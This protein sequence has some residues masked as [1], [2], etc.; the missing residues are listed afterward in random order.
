MDGTLRAALDDL[1]LRVIDGAR[2]EGEGFS[3]DE[4]FVARLEVILH[5][6]QVPP[7]AVQAGRAIVRDKL[8]DRFS[9]LGK[10]F[11][12]QGYDRATNRRGLV[13]F[14]IRDLQDVAPV[15]CRRGRSHN[16]SRMV[17]TP[18]RANCAA[19]SGPTPR[20]SVTGRARGSEAAA[21]CA[22]P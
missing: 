17:S 19:R 16:K 6:R 5:V 1:G 7:A 21:G 11:D 12:A 9:A 15:L 3:E 14:Q 8:K 13:Q 18:S 22:A 2:L 4:H 20:N 10:A